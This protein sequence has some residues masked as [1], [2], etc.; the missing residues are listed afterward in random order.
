M[1]IDMIESILF[2]NLL[3]KKTQ[4]CSLLFDNEWGERT[5]FLVNTNH[6]APQKKKEVATSLP[7]EQ[8]HLDQT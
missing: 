4:L 5:T 3:T 6:N 7:T 8:T 2:Q 1:H